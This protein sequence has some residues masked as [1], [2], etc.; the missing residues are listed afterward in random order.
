MHHWC[1]QYRDGGQ[2]QAMRCMQF[3]IN[4]KACVNEGC[5]QSTKRHENIKGRCDQKVSKI[6]ICLYFISPVLMSVLIVTIT[7]RQ[8]LMHWEA[9]DVT[10]GGTTALYQ[11]SPP[12]MSP[13][14]MSVTSMVR[15]TTGA[16]QVQS[17][18]ATVHHLAELSQ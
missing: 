13:V 2:G 11:G 18:G 3:T 5:V 6:E 12:I 9:E 8:M 17:P 7:A 16:T 1:G 4:G 14:Q 10:S 15:I